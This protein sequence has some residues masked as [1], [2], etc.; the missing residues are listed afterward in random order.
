MQTFSFLSM[1]SS[2]VTLLPE[3]V[4][5]VLCV[6]YYSKRKSID[7]ILLT[8]G[9][10]V[11]LTLGAFFRLI[12]MVYSTFYKKMT[13]YNLFFVTSIVGFLSSTCFAIGLGMVLTEAIKRMNS[14]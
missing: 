10:A 7:G 8:I 11:G 14:N 9:S 5:F 4:V 3:A 6:Y 13:T 1:L 12:P 2:L